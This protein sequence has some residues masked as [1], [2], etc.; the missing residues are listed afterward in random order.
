M[1]LREIS[2]IPF[3]KAAG[4]ISLQTAAEKNYLLS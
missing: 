4:E 3:N 1:I 2:P